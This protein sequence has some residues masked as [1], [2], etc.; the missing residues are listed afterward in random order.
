MRGH[1]G[2]P[3]PSPSPSRWPRTHEPAVVALLHDVHPVALQQLQFVGVLGPVLVQC[4]VPA[5]HSVARARTT[6]GPA[7]GRR[8][9]VSLLALLTGST[10]FRSRCRTGQGRG[11]CWWVPPGLCTA[12]GGGGERMGA[13]LRVSTHIPGG[14]RARCRGWGLRRGGCSPPRG[15][16]SGTGAPGDGRPQVAEGRRGPARGSGRRRGAALG[17]GGRRSQGGGA[18][19]GTRRLRRHPAL[20]PGGSWRK[21]G[22][23]GDRA[24]AAGTGSRPGAGG[25]RRRERVGSPRRWFSPAAPSPPARRWRGRCP[26]GWCRRYVPRTSSHPPAAPGRPA[27]PADGTR[28]WVS[29]ARLGTARRGAARHGGTLRKESSTGS[30]PRKL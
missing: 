17:R 18:R 29:T 8:A 27:R 22:D 10:G 3:S 2:N 4:P 19:T 7:W 16:R 21:A 24:S 26:D 13:T 28:G 20:P 14:P 5:R 15:A 12:R 11:G 30:S 25:W 1:G 6:T 9:T 23:P